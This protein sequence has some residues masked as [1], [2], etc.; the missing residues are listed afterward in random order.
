[1]HGLSLPV[2]GIERAEGLIVE[3]GI[4]PAPETRVETVLQQQTFVTPLLRDGAVPQ[5]DDLVRARS[6]SATLIR[7]MGSG[8]QSR[9]RRSP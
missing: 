8:N 7:G 6:D 4:V 2:S 5:D 1:M 9:G 3:R